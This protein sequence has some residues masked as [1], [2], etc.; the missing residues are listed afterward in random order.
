MST[1]AEA[2]RAAELYCAVSSDLGLK[3]TTGPAGG[4]QHRVYRGGPPPMAG[5][6]LVV[7]RLK[8]RKKVGGF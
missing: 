7:C 3:E 4:S 1:A 5:Q 8:L 2:A 6:P